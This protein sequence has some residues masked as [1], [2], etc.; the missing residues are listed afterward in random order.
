M[1][2]L[3]SRKES[4]LFSLRI[5]LNF[6]LFRFYYQVTFLYEPVMKLPCSETAACAAC[7]PNQLVRFRLILQRIQRFL[8]RTFHIITEFTGFILSVSFQ[9]HSH[10]LLTVRGDL[11]SYFFSRFKLLVPISLVAIRRGN[12]KANLPS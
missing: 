9:R 11:I 5:M 7:L 8:H 6:F 1:W 12:G 4:F 2:R 3:Q 10:R